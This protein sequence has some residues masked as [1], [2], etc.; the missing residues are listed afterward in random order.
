VWEAWREAPRNATP[1]ELLVHV[2]WTVGKAP[3]CRRHGYAASAAGRA[4]SAAALETRACPCPR[5]R[6]EC[7]A[8]T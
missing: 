1:R 2:P 4:A 7:A 8:G 6:R 3:S 5:A